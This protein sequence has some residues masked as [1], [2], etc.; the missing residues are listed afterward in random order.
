M[1]ASIHQPHFLPWMGYFN[2]V[3]H[4]DVFV[5]LHNVQ[6]RKN[7]FQNRTKIKN[8]RTD[9]AFWLT[10]PVKA[11]LDTAID[12][13]LQADTKWD[14]KAIGTI[15][16]FYQHAPFYKGWANDLTKFFRA[17]DKNLDELNF[18]LFCFLLNELNYKGRIVRVENLFPLNEDPNQ[19][20]IEICEKVGANTYI[21]GKGGRNY[22]DLPRWDAAD[23]QVQ[24][25][26]FDAGSIT[27]PQLGNTFL[28]GLSIIDCIF[29]VGTEETAKI[30]DSAWRPI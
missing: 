8:P 17:S 14:R 18:E 16:Q 9:E 15:Q 6:Y 21:A 4:S 2:K 30:I 3:F 12:Q 23:I 5:W 19:R 10:V 29:N 28:P 22:V 11:S 13:V 1:I 26:D 7:Y 27:Y 24:W 20:L 25:Q